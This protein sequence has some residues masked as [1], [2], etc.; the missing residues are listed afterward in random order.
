MKPDNFFDFLVM[1]GCYLAREDR[2]SEGI[3]ENG[4]GGVGMRRE[5]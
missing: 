2:G 3:G 4:E 1:Y 5:R